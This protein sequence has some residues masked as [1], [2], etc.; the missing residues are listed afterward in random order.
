[1]SKPAT[2]P[3]L[4]SESK[5]KPVK[6]TK[7]IRAEQVGF[8]RWRLVEETFG[9]PISTKVLNESVTRVGAEDRV[10]L[11]LETQLGFNR[12]GDSGLE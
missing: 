11:Y 1:M 10:R 9:A 12:F 6:P 4:R 2:A 8:N 3:S 5:T 7:R